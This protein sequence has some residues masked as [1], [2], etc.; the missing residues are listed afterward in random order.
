MQSAPASTAGS[1]FTNANI[2]NF[3]SL[4]KDNTLALQGG[5]QSSGTG[6]AFPTTQSA[7]SD[8]NTLDDYEEG[9]WTPVIYTESGSS[10][11]LSSTDCRYQKV[12]NVVH[13]QASI[14]YSAKGSQALAYITL[15][16]IATVT[17]AIYLVGSCATPTANNLA[18][19][20]LLHYSG[21]NT[22]Y[23]RVANAD[24]YYFTNISFM[25]SS[26]AIRF[27]G[28]FITSQ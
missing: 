17:N 18:D 21:G 1:T 27:W 20:A 5:T 19:I 25:A 8:A 13:V 28:S 14:N 2:T 24:S 4:K 12:G 7:S 11:T 3:F 23:F 15:P 6:I 10:F 26:G 22:A 9:T 16:F